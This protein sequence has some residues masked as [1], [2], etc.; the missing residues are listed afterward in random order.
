MVRRIRERLGK[1]EQ[2]SVPPEEKYPT[3]ALLVLEPGETDTEAAARQGVD[4]NRPNLHLIRFRIV[5][6]IDGKPAP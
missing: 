3:G 6:A 4:L 1:L 5:D 2:A